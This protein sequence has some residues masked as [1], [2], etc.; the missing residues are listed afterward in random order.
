MRELLALR[1]RFTAVFA[2]ND[3][4]ALGAFIACRE[5][6]IRVPADIAIAGFD[7]IPAARLV[8]PALTTVAQFPERTG[9]HA[10]EQLMDRLGGRYTGPTRL[11]LLQHKLIVRESA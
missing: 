11:D 1:P 4:M 9:R 8:S 2:A 5:R 10:A 6:G 7:D 3:L